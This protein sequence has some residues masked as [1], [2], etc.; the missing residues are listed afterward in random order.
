[1]SRIIVFEKR[2]SGPDGYVIWLDGK[3]MAFEV[4]LLPENNHTPHLEL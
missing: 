2:F 1:M 3:T 4:N